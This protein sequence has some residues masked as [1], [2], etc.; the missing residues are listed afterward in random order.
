MVTEMY[1]NSFKRTF[2]VSLSSDVT[3]LAG[4]I[5]KFSIRVT[6][7]VLGHI[8]VEFVCLNNFTVLKVGWYK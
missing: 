6:A 5:H 4:D 8:S 3:V 1:I 7:A 2:S